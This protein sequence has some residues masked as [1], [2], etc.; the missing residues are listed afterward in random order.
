MIP[1]VSAMLLRST[2]SWIKPPPP[3]SFAGL[4][5]LYEA[6]YIRFRRLCPGFEDIKD[7]CAVSRVHGALDLHLKLLARSRHTSTVGL[8]Y[9]LED[10]HGVQ[11]PNPDLR[12]RVYHDAL[13]T[14]VLSYSSIP[15][16]HARYADHRAALLR[17]WTMNR[18]LFRWL[19]Y[20]VGQGH[21]YSST[22][23]DQVGQPRTSQGVVLG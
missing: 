23:A 18:F 10:A 5:E 17:N 7:G 19:G 1:I 14:Q 20:C 22:S 11:R 12:L 15:V 21:I 6:N 16:T 4:M 13:Q 3:R 9:Y 2:C 8:T